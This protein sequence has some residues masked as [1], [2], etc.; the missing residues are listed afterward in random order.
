MSCEDWKEVKLGDVCEKI[1]YGYTQSAV[2]EKIG[3]KF[4][5]ITDIREQYF[6]WRSV[7]YCDISKSDF[8]KYRLYPGDIVIAR[9]GATTGIS[10]Y[11]DQTVPNAVFASYLIR[12][13]VKDGINSRFIGYVVSSKKYKRY[14]KSILS[15]SAQPNANAKQLT[16]FLFQLPPKEEQN[17]IS[18]ILSSL[19]DKIELNHQI[20]QDL[21]EM[22]QAI[23]KSWFVDFEPFRDGE[24]VDSELG[25]IPKGWRVDKLGNVSTVTGGGTPKTKVP[26]YWENGN[27]LWATPSDMTS[28]NSMVLFDTSRK[29]T[30]LGLQNSSAKLLPKGSVLM[31]SRATIGYTSIAMKEVS[32]NQG[33]INIVCNKQIS[34]Y[35]MLCYLLH[36][37]DRI[38]RLAN[39]S[40]FMEV[41]KRNFKEINVVVPPHNLIEKFNQYIEP[42]IETIYQ[43]EQQNQILS[44]LRDTLLPKLMSGEIRV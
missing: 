6:D 26:D 13:R 41:S 25:P 27:I 35:Y 21:E 39:G 22:A 31:T 2:K 5:R 24:F 43:H 44:N 3:P 4:L 17:K 32:T 36:F 33:F 38:L 8:L 12:I 9:T 30:E 18:E 29:I 34:N 1:Q 40:T 16:S 28:K 42:I 11:I 19:D 23:F 7:P 37:K 15:G 14:I 10:K 20:N